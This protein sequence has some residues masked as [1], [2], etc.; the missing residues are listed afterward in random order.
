MSL[1]AQSLRDELIVPDLHHFDRRTPSTESTISEID[2][3]TCTSSFFSLTFQ[4]VDFYIW[5]L[6]CIHSLT[7]P[8]WK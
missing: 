7:R 3:G 1:T 8:I 6:S 2:D 4:V 5:R